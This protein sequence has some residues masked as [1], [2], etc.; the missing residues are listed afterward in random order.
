[1]CSIK[2]LQT[3]A[4]TEN[5]SSK[6]Y[7]TRNTEHKDNSKI[8]TWTFVSLLLVQ[9]SNLLGEIESFPGP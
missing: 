8:G 6:S 2:K 3:H 5:K 1:M 9:D 7:N 4:H